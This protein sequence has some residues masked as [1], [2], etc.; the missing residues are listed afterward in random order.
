MSTESRYNPLLA[1][2]MEQMKGS[3]SDVQGIDDFADT[4]RKF[5]VGEIEI[6]EAVPRMM[7]FFT[8]E[9]GG[10]S[11]ERQRLVTLAQSMKSRAGMVPVVLMTFTTCGEALSCSYACC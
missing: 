4:A 2:L 10:N 5:V 8:G 9:I 11:V 1:E 3:M 7:S 6:D